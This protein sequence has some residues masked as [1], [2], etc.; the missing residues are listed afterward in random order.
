M[1]RIEKETL[2]Y[3]LGYCEDKELKVRDPIGQEYEIIGAGTRSEKEEV[4]EL[5]I[6]DNA[7]NAPDCIVVLPDEESDKLAK[8]IEVLVQEHNED[9][10]DLAIVQRQARLLLAFVQSNKDRV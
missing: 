6:R 4:V 7:I 8:I 1:K 3:L 2:K 10:I 9:R 5:I